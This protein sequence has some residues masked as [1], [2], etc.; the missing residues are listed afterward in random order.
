M[1]A[2]SRKIRNNMEMASGGWG[3]WG[4][5]TLEQNLTIIAS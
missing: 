4:W 5:R 1:D 3:A 2:N